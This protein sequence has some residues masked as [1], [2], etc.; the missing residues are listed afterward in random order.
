LN[1]LKIAMNTC[2]KGLDR[3]C[4]GETR[5]TLEQDVPVREQTKQKTADHVLLPYDDLLA[6]CQNPVHKCAFSVNLLIERGNIYA[7]LCR[8]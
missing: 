5:K 1:P 2:R 6:V 7:C 8:A 3:K 4:L